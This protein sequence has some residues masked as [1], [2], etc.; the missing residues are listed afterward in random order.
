MRRSSPQH[1][2]ADVLAV[3][4]ERCQQVF[5]VGPDVEA[6]HQPL[7]G[8]DRDHGLPALI[9]RDL[10]GLNSRYR[11]GS[12]GVHAARASAMT[13]CSPAARMGGPSSN[14]FLVVF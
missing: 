14:G 6:L 7:A 9:E 4:L 2:F 10:D 13:G 11:L 8:D 3:G 1:G 5:L 12:C